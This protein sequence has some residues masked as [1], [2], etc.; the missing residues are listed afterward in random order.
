M[1]FL[2][3]LDSG[4]IPGTAFDR[5]WCDAVKDDSDLLIRWSKLKILRNLTLKNHFSSVFEDSVID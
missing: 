2:I 3:H 1:I 4:D 5:F